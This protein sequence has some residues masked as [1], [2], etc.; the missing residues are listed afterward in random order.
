[1]SENQILFPSLNTA[2]SSM[3]TA[4]DGSETELRL[5][6]RSSLGLPADV[7]DAQILA[8]FD[9][10]LLRRAI[11]L[12]LPANA[13]AKEIEEAEEALQVSAA[14]A[15]EE[16]RLVTAQMLGHSDRVGAEPEVPDPALDWSH[17][18]GTDGD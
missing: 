11:A 3:L 9:T 6:F 18:F 15:A 17:L 13:N 16:R 7:T 4:D 5:K 14:A 10:M 1:M 2:T 8:V 12:G